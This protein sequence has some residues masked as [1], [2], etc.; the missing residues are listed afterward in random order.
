V[1]RVQNE[2]RCVFAMSP[3]SLQAPKVRLGQLGKVI[4]K[5]D[6]TVL[7]EDDV[8]EGLSCSA[9]ALKPT[10]PSTPCMKKSAD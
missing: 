5:E 7:D 2:R 8:V 6:G 1:V 4:R 10:A 3:R 9:R